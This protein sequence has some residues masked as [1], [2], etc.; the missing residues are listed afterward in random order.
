MFWLFWRLPTSWASSLIV[1]ISCVQ[2]SLLNSIQFSKTLPSTGNQDELLMETSN[3]CKLRM[4]FGIEIF[5]LNLASFLHWETEQDVRSFL[6]P[7][8]PTSIHETRRELFKFTISSIEKWRQR[9]LQARRKYYDQIYL[10]FLGKF[11]DNTL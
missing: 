11:R 10:S 9:W 1:R 7:P 6:H 5:F 3:C 8:S 4:I 2:I